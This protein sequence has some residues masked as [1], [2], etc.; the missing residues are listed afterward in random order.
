MLPDWWDDALEDTSA[1]LQQAKLILAKTFSLDYQSLDED[2]ACFRFGLHQFKHNKNLN[3]DRLKPAV[4]MAMLSAKIT[5]SVFDK[6][7]MTATKDP[8]LI[9]SELLNEDHDWIDF[10]TLA[11]WCWL[12]GIPVIYTKNLPSPK[13][14]GLAIE[15][16]DR[17]VIVLTKNIKHGALIFDLAHE[18]GHIL[19]G[20]TKQ[21]GGIMVDEKLNT[22][23]DN[24][25]E[26]QANAF[27]LELLTGNKDS[28]FSPAKD[29]SPNELAQ[30]M[31]AKGRKYR[32][33]PLHICRVYAYHSRKFAYAALVTP[34]I[35]QE[36]NTKK[37]DQDFALALY[38]QYVDMSAV[39]DDEIIQYLIGAA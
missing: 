15:Y 36:L 29:Y 34:I 20:H 24:D 28:R 37:S 4:S 23:A 19:L 2:Q 31:I 30:A 25:M 32:I 27:A 9:R 7:L 14:D 17:P 6:P 12:Q 33:D 26:A 21:H 39:H 35:A 10:K 38:L 13:M 18:L 16:N 3:K 5:L 11:N 22:R 8:L 1:G